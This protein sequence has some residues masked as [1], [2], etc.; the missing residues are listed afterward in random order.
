MILNIGNSLDGA[1][2]VFTVPVAGNY[3]FSFYSVGIGDSNG[4]CSVWVILNGHDKL[5][6]SQLIAP[7]QGY[8]QISPTWQMELKTGDKIHM[9]TN[10]GSFYTDSTHYP[11]FIGELVSEQVQ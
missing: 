4:V 10:Q 6:F 3:Q 5:R 9:Q 8:N 11:I 7:N 2:G 1:S